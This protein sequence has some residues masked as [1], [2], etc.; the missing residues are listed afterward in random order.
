M[1][2]VKLG[3]VSLMAA[4]IL[5]VIFSIP[6]CVKTNDVPESAPVS[7]IVTDEN[8]SSDFHVISNIDTNV[9]KSDTGISEDTE[10]LLA[11]AAAPAPA[12]ETIRDHQ[13][14]QVR[15][16]IS[17]YSMTNE[18][19]GIEEGGLV[20]V[21]QGAELKVHSKFRSGGGKYMYI[22]NPKEKRLGSFERVM[23]LFCGGRV[24][25]LD[26]KMTFI[27]EDPDGEY[28]IARKK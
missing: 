8:T 26:E 16:L 11:A 27:D 15:W 10:F 20:E 2:R 24:I 23:S 6:S 14:A 5:F 19:I 17:L 22:V 13:I 28:V 9:W 25:T 1:N 12:P 3:Y 7:H 21:T 4:L 18:E